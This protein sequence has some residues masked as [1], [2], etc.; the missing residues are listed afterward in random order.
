MIQE[1]GLQVRLSWSAAMMAA[2]LLVC[3]VPGYGETKKKPSEADLQTS[4]EHQTKGDALDEDGKSDKAIEEYTLAL[5]YNPDDTNTLFNMGT[6]YLKINRPDDAAK[7]FE[8][9]VK[10]DGKDA[11]AY[12]LLGLA[13]RGCGRKAEAMDAW[14]KSLSIN[15][16]QTLPKKF[17]EEAK[18]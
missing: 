10:I 6:V 16:G 13:Y 17:M 4:L 12:N 11:E 18:D 5:K 9:I 8:A 2:V 3:A 15:P 1:G 14:R 7:A